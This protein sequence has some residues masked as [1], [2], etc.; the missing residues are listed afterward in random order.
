MEKLK[1]SEKMMQIEFDTK[2]DIEDENCNLKRE[3]E[4]LTRQVRTLNEVIIEMDKTHRTEI[5]RL[6]KEKIKQDG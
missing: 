6:R 1:L 4:R 5:E 2:L 3:I